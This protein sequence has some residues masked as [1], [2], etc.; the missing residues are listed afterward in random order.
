[1]TDHFFRDFQTAPRLHEG[2]LGVYVDAFAALLQEQGYSPQSARMQTRL[3]ADLSRWLRRKGLAANDLS[4]HKSSRHILS[5]ASIT[6]VPS[7]AM[8]QRCRGY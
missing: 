2:P 6:C 4:P 3:V 8:L 5:I 7:A 1:M